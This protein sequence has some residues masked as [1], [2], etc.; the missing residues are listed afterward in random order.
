M[1]QLTLNFHDIP[2]AEL[3]TLLGAFRYE[4]GRYPHAVIQQRDDVVVKH[5]VHYLLRKGYSEE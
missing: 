5:A 3:V 1:A 4:G 2:I